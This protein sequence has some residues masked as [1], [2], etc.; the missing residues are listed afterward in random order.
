MSA[1]M[2]SG[3]P[4]QE[5]MANLIRDNGTEPEVRFGNGVLISSDAGGATEHHRPGQKEYSSLVRSRALP[6]VVQPQTTDYRELHD[7]L[8]TADS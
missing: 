1:C 2:L 7:Q 3:G 5:P 6:Q 4:L 8:T